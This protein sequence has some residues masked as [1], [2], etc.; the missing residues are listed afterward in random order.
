MT[1]QK[2]MIEINDDFLNELNFSSLQEM[3]DHA[4]QKSHRVMRAII[5]QWLT[6]SEGTEISPQ[7]ICR[8]CGSQANYVSRRAAFADT[9]FG[10]VRYERAYYV[11]PHCHASTCPLDERINP[12]ESLAR[13]RM[14]ISAGISLPVAEMAHDWGLGSLN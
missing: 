1:P 3:E 9:R 13:L 4:G 8:E 2:K 14:K 12:V 6:M 10:L 11:C 5:S 7:T